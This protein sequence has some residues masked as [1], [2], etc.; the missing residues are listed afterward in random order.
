MIVV[1][2]P[3][4]APM[5]VVAPL[6]PMAMI[7]VVPVS[8]AMN[9]L[10]IAVLAGV[11]RHVLLVVPLVAY[12]VDRPAASVVLRAM[13]APVPFVSGRYVQVNRLDC[14]VLGRP[15]GNDRLCINNGRRRNSADVDLPEEARLTNAD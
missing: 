5:I 8:A 6:V 14:N 7:I 4:P 12:E 10:M 15:N 3:V 11:A 1:V 9:I 2:I 13:P